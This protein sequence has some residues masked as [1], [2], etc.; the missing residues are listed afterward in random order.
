MRFAASESLHSDDQVLLLEG[1][2]ALSGDGARFELLPGD[3]ASVSSRH[4]SMFGNPGDATARYLVVKRHY[5][6]PLSGPAAPPSH[7]MERP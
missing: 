4:E 2:L 3:C 1:R 6:Q 7:T 5:R